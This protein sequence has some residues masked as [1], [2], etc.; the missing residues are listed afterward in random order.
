MN[1]GTHQWIIRV[2]LIGASLCTFAALLGAQPSLQITT[3][4]NGSVVEPGATIAMSVRGQLNLP[5]TAS[6]AHLPQGH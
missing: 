5:P 2:S 1:Y 4:A 6:F 3:P